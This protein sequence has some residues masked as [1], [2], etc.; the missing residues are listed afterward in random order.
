MN[1]KTTKKENSKRRMIAFGTITKGEM[2]LFLIEN[3]EI[4]TKTVNQ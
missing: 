2:I 3:E 4:P 1:K